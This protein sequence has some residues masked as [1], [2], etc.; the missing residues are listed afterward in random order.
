MQKERQW[1]C[2][3]SWLLALLLWPA[4]RSTSCLNPQIHYP[5]FNFPKFGDTVPEI[6]GNL[7][8][9]KAHSFGRRFGLEQALEKIGPT[10][11]PLFID[12]MKDRDF[13]TRRDAAWVLGQSQWDLS[14]AVRTLIETLH[15]EDATVRREAIMCLRKISLQDREVLQTLTDALQGENAI[16]RAGAALTLLKSSP[17]GKTAFRVL[18]EALSEK[19]ERVRETT[20]LVLWDFGRDKCPEVITI[21][22]EALKSDDIHERVEAAWCLNMVFQ[23][24]NPVVVSSIIEAQKDPDARVRA[25]TALTLTARRPWWIGMTLIDEA[26]DEIDRNKFAS[27]M[28][29]PGPELDQV[30]S[31]LTE[32]LSYKDAWIRWRAAK[33]LGRI[34]PDAK[35]SIPV[36][37]EGMRDE[38]KA[39]RVE[40]ALALWRV[41]RQSKIAVPLLLQTLKSTSCS[42]E[43][44]EGAF[45]GEVARKA[46]IDA[47]GEIGP[48]AKEAIPLLIEALQK[49]PFSNIEAALALWWIDRQAKTAVAYL[50]NVLKDNQVETNRSDAAWALGEIGPEAAGAVPDLLEAFND[51]VAWVRASAA[52]AVW[53]ITQDSN[54]AVPVL[55]NVL[56]NRSDRPYNGRY[57]AAWA[58]GEIGSEARDAVPVLVDALKDPDEQVRKK[59]AEVLKR[60][61]PEEARRVGVP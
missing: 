45:S 10:A 23:L 5:M 8:T 18:V 55:I 39:V 38:D 27:G 26:L 36:L 6:L 60:I 11:M 35:A 40:A 34:G 21:L 4:L 47:L 15:D 50:L 19:A 56:K 58:L 14:D 28:R 37:L 1:P 7:K 41:G 49:A 9:K 43:V 48:E 53:K 44:L 13:R 54:T 3:P 17:E 29:G 42:E 22:I 25:W 20:A 12:A 24:D 32:S 57:F 16:L 61:D 46:A 52:L 51:D 2:W 33:E 59:V 31:V 30:V